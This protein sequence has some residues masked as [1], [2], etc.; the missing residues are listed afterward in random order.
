MI[1]S[2][3]FAPSFCRRLWS[4]RREIS[5][6]RDD[7]GRIVASS[8]DNI[9]TVVKTMGLSPTFDEFSREVQINGRAIDDVDLDRIWAA[10]CSAV[11][12]PDAPPVAP[13]SP[14]PA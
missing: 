7:A 8:L 6:V 10:D 11:P 2:A 4:Q 9:R 13:G 14:A 5:L 1:A 3:S 12:E